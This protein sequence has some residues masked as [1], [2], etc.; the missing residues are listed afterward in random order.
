MASSSF[1]SNSSNPSF[2]AENPHH[3]WRTRM[4]LAETVDFS[5]IF[6]FA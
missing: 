2:T 6:P 3:L 5:K 4:I 1:R